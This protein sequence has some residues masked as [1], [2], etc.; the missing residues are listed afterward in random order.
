MME[1]IIIPLDAHS[2]EQV[3]QVNWNLTDVCKRMVSSRGPHWLR[4]TAHQL[5]KSWKSKMPEEKSLELPANLRVDR[6]ISLPSRP[7]KV[8]LISTSQVD[9]QV[10]P[11]WSLLIFD[12]EQM[13]VCA[14]TYIDYVETFKNGIV[15][16]HN[17]VV[18]LCQQ[19]LRTYDLDMLKE[20]HDFNTGDTL[21]LL[22]N[23]LDSSTGS[24]NMC[25]D[26][27]ALTL[28]LAA[29]KLGYTHNTG[30][31]P[32]LALAHKNILFLWPAGAGTKDAVIC[33]YNRDTDTIL[34]T[35]EHVDSSTTDCL[36]AS[37]T[38]M[39]VLSRRYFHPRLVMVDA[40][41]GEAKATL[42]PF[43]H[44]SVGAAFAMGTSMVWFDVISV[45]SMHIRVWDSNTSVETNAY[46]FSVRKLYFW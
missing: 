19:Q 17:H 14:H 20:V 39:V 9:D 34:W 7:N 12:I 35:K 16:S 29:K 24:F 45:C 21:S 1:K 11:L 33:A 8:L 5:C 36:D 3:M 27:D 18:V 38:H 2:L 40:I 4:W 23:R 22:Y 37:D 44:D 15:I 25:K 32:A 41:T 46:S 30:S 28:K 31:V 26:I 10:E 42:R 43:D 6:C 13:A